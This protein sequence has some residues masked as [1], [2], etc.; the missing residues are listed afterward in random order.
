MLE[1]FSVVQQIE[2]DMRHLWIN[3][4]FILIT[5]WFTVF[6][7]SKSL[8]QNGRMGTGNLLP[9]HTLTPLFPF[10]HA[11]LLREWESHGWDFISVSLRAPVEVPP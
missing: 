4:V 8:E 1:L 5:T 10:I 3:Q 6:N 2:N 9:S 11:Q 7:E